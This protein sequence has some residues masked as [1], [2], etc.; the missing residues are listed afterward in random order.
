[1]DEIDQDHGYD[2]SASKPFYSKEHL[3]K[4]KYKN[5]PASIGIKQI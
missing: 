2:F 4:Y 1:M 3:K 5:K